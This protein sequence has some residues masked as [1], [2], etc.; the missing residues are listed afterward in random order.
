MIIDSHVHIIVPEATHTKGSEG[1]WR[2]KVYYE[3]GKQIVEIRGRRFQSDRE[4]VNIDLILEEQ[5]KAGIDMVLISPIASLMNYEAE[6]GEGLRMCKIQNEALAKITQKYPDRV[7]ALGIIPLQ[8][9][10]LAA[11]ELANVMQEPGLEGVIVGTS[12]AANYLGDE[13]F[14][15]FWS[16][17]EETAAIIFI[18]PTT[19]AFSD[20]V[21]NESQLWKSVGNPLETTIA[22]S[23][24][25]M[26]GTMERYPKLKIVLAHGGG[27]ILSLRG[28]LQKSFSIIS[29]EKL[30]LK[31]SPVES[32]K[33]FYFD[34][35]THDKEVLINLIDFVGPDRVLLGSDYPF[36]MG[37]NFPLETLDEINL[38]K[39]SVSK[40]AGGN[41]A[42][43]M[44]LQ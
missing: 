6:K 15:A 22:T 28:R 3:E 38:S 7:R 16:A 30:K 11:K 25:V 35:L 31:E 33:R 13:R 19:R 4:I 36:D 12:V 41:I 21:F 20:K 43:L 9:P 23:H 10:N 40:I 44:D 17:A 8:D 14:E 24:L 37:H 42:R 1:S 5:T 2:P 26:T 18:H 32:L 34:S 27:G 29:P 39:E